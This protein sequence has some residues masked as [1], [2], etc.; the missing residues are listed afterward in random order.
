MRR[1]LLT[2]FVGAIVLPAGCV[3]PSDGTP[4]S[5]DLADFGVQPTITVTV[6]DDGF[7][8]STVEMAANSTIAVTNDGTDPHGVL[9]V[10]TAADRRIE[11]GDLMPGETVAIHLADP[12]PIELTDPHSGASLDLDVGPAAPIR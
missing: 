1:L 10:D 9:Q 4:S 5:A 11:T 8:P 12:G 7:T 3:Q 6:D 2:V